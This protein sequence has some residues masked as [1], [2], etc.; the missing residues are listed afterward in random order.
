MKDREKALRYFDK[1][2]KLDACNPIYLHNKGCC[3]RRMERFEE[4]LKSLYQALKLDPENCQIYSTIGYLL[5]TN[6]VLR[7]MDRIDEAIKAY[8][9]ELSYQPSS[10]KALNHRAF[11]YSKKGDFQKAILDY[12]SVLHLDQTNL[13]SLHNKES[14]YSG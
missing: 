5:L 7:K 14:L 9:T 8:T 2:L 4:S 1:A 11:C 13:N 10:M 6:S 3:L 12:D